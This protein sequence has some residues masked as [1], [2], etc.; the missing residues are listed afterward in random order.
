MTFFFFFAFPDYCHDLVFPNKNEE[1]NRKIFIIQEVYYH[2]S[3]L[4]IL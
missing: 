3:Y 4:V 1:F 2:G